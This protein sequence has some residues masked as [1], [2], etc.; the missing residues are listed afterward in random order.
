MIE[1]LPLS[2]V[3][4]WLVVSFYVIVLL[5]VVSKMISF[6]AFRQAQRWLAQNK[7]LIHEFGVSTDLSPVEF[8]YLFD[9][10]FRDEEL[11]ALLITMH[12]SRILFIEN[13]KDDLTIRQVPRNLQKNMG[14]LELEVL[15]YLNSQGGQGLWSQF[16]KDLKAG[17]DLHERFERFIHQDLEQKGYFVHGT[18]G[19]YGRKI[20]NLQ[21]WLGTML[22][23]AFV[24]IPFRQSFIYSQQALGT[25]FAAVD[26]MVIGMLLVFVAFCFWPAWY[27]YVGLAAK[28]IYHSSG[29]PLGATQKLRHD[30]R[31]LYGYKVFLHKVEKNRL[32][33]DPGISDKAMPWCVAIG[34]G[35]KPEKMF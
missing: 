28:I 10:K 33:V 34:V 29:I 23:F 35:P 3:F 22:S 11:L 31:I 26:Q 20:Q 13:R 1:S 32:A 14:M 16:S 21:F 27:L 9:R 5:L 19:L 24:L 25:G 30:W 8:G 17:S 2:S 7:S 18:L 15:S 4:V 6:L 12:Q